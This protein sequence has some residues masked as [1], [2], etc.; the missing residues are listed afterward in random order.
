MARPH[1]PIPIDTIRMGIHIRAALPNT[2]IKLPEERMTT[3]IERDGPVTTIV[4]ARTQARNAMDP[5]SAEAL[6]ADRHAD[7][8]ERY[9]AEAEAWR[10]SQRQPGS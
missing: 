1:P 4:R 2:S 8:R 5:A 3:T 10:E 6:T 7:T 9:L